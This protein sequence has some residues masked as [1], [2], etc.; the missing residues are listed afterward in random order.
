MTGSFYLPHLLY[1]EM[2]TADTSCDRKEINQSYQL[3]CRSLVLSICCCPSLRIKPRKQTGRYRQWMDQKHLASTAPRA[4]VTPS[5]RP[6]W[7]AARMFCECWR[8]QPDIVQLIST[9]KKKMI[10]FRPDVNSWSCDNG[11]APYVSD[12]NVGLASRS[13]NGCN[14]P[15]LSLQ[16]AFVMY[17]RV[18]QC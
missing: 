17:Q 8:K 13:E 6:F 2:E 12:V 1:G 18:R 16:C 11:F 7:R 14:S 5:A 9:A 15:Q 10:K 3:H 4:W